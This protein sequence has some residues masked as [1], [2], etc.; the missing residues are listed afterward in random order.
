M[1]TRYSL[2]AFII[3]LFLGSTSIAQEEP[4]IGLVPQSLIED[5]G[6]GA[7]I[8]SG[9]PPR[10]IIP[11]ALDMIMHFE[12]WRPEAHNDPVG[13]CTIGYGHLIALDRCENIDLG[14]FSTPLTKK[15]GLELLERD[16]RSSRSAV[17]RLVEVELDDDQFSALSVFTF[18]VGKGNF[19]KSTLLT[20][21][22]LSEFGPATRQFGR[23]V[24]AKKIKLPGLVIRRAC[25]ATLFVGSLKTNEAGNFSRDFCVSLGIAPSAEQPIDV[26][27]GE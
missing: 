25:E 12:G 20:L 11:V 8:T 14:E 10:P 27:S 17:Q 4:N 15:Q 3:S 21:V 18:N 1:F 9:T 2:S 23:W 19:E 6:A 16:T 7:G 22:N 5:L 24:T 26:L 13:Y